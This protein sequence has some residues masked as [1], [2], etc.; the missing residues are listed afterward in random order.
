MEEEPQSGTT[1]V[2]EPGAGITQWYSEGQKEFVENKGW[3]DGSSAVQSYI[4]LE[5]SQGGKVKIPTEQSTAEEKS[6]FYRSI[7][8]PEG[9]DGYEIKDVPG[10]IVRDEAAELVL[11]GVAF[12]GGCPK[13]TFEAIVK[14]FYQ[15][16]S[17]DLVASRTESESLL[18]D[19]WSKP[20]QYDA[21]IEIAQ[22]AINELFSE[23]TKAL[24]DATGLG[25]NSTLVKDFHNIGVKMLNDTIIQGTPSGGNEKSEE[26]KP[27]WINSPEMY[28]H[29]DDEESIKAREYFK[30][31]G[32]VYNN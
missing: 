17:D 20:G 16:Q 19:E 12:E 23:E 3:K 6:S 32:H 9:P 30:K 26:Y 14:A 15:K 29:G 25:N 7:G 27:R 11:K 18:K 28:E 22:R 1:L 2:T 24:L 21:N 8:V 4:D 5:K 10:N 31:Q 13:A